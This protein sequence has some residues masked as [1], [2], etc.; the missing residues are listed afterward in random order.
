M[1]I[2]IPLAVIVS[3]II[4]VLGVMQVAQDL[5]IWADTGPD[6]SDDE[7]AVDEASNANPA[8][9][10]EG[11]PVRAKRHVIVDRDG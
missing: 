4:L 8:T 7:A 9:P 6:C 11:H 5:L 3:V 1:H 10:S 2:L